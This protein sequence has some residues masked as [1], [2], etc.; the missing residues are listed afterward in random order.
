MA[1]AV[2]RRGPLHFRKAGDNLFAG[3]HGFIDGVRTLCFEVQVP[4]TDFLG[5]A[6]WFFLSPRWTAAEKDK[7]IDLRLDFK[8]L[9]IFNISQIS[10][11]P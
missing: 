6:T 8:T 4:V 1:C 10:T 3:M 2:C 9:H 5:P 11:P 7:E